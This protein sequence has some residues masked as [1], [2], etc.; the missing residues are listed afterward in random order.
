MITEGIKNLIIDLGGVIVNL[1]RNRCIEAFEQ[2]GVADVRENVVNNYQHKDLFM[3]LELGLISAAE[4]RSGIRRLAGRPLTDKQIDRAWMAM[5]GDIP[6]AR[7]DLL[8][9]LRGRYRTFLLS[10]T[11]VIH[12]EWIRQNLLCREGVSA[13]DFFH[14]IYLSYELHKLK[15]NADIFDY[16]LQDAA[17]RPE[18]TLLIDDAP[19]NCRMAEQLSMRAYNVEAGEDWS[20]IFH[21]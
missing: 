21:F 15:P 19:A 5:L 7:L 1:T 9:A 2:L 6:A 13:S 16:V 10:N 3:Q 8:L 20:A 17:L 11:N 14:K 4:F 12:W 18:E